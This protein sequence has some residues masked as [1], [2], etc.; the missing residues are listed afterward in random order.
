MAPGSRSTERVGIVASVTSAGPSPAAAGTADGEV[1]D[2]P[3][4]QPDPWQ[5][6]GLRFF[7]G[8]LW[9]EHVADAGVASI[10]S[11]PVAGRE[12]SRPAPERAA[13]PGDAVGARVLPDGGAAEAVL[14]AEA[15]LLLV[16]PVEEG[17]SRA[18]S[19]PDDDEVGRIVPGRRWALARLGRAL[20]AEPSPRVTRLVVHDATG[21]E[22]LSLARPLRR[23]AATVDVAGPAGPLGRV[24]A[25]RVVQELRARV[26]AADGRELGMLVKAG[27]A[28]SPLGV[29]AEDGTLRARLTP[30]WDVPGRRRHLPP[31]V[32]LLDRRSPPGE[33]WDAPE[34]A[35]LLAALLSP[36]LL[37]P[38]A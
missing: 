28:A 2:P 32:L 1:S 11:T 36:P 26:V 13:P 29:A 38:P 23:M 9:T 17:G 7:D 10:D 25:D 4:W 16:G 6:H 5:R 12:R 24:V 8:R 18:L 15:P 31:G 20:V 19:T 30:V 37:R 35:L 27:A 3:G 33:T 21:A 14:L 34:A 22:A